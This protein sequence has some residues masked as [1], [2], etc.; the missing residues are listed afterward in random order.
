MLPQSWEL[1]RAVQR[2][3]IGHERPT[4]KLLLDWQL[5]V[6]WWVEVQVYMSS[7][8]VSAIPG[9]VPLWKFRFHVFGVRAGAVQVAWAT[10]QGVIPLLSFRQQS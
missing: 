6:S 5:E 10:E 7:D 2:D 9:F 1:C 8:S 3:H 4:R